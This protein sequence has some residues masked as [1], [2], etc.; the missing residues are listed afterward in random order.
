MKY[1][2]RY[3][4]I[5][6]LGLFCMSLA[7]CV[8]VTPVDMD[9]IPQ[10]E[11]FKRD[12]KKWAEEEEALRKNREDSIALVEK[13]KKLR[14]KYL[15]DLREYKKS[16]HILMFGWFAY[17]NPTSPDKTFSLDHLPDSMDFVSNWGASWNLDQVK[18]D[19]L[20]RLHE[21][22]TRM[23]IGWI[24]EN[25]GDGLRNAP[26]GG[27]SN[28]PYTAIDQYAQ[29]LCD[30]IAKYNYDGIDIDYEPQ[31]ASP[32]KPGNHC[33][34][35]T[36]PWE[37]T[38]ALISCSPN[39]N[40]EYENY[41]FRKLDELLPEEKLLNIN[42]SIGWIDPEVADVFDYFVFQSYGNSARSWK[43]TAETLMSRNPNI[44]P[45]QFIYTESFQNNPANAAAFMR[46]ADFVKNNLGGKVGGIGAFHINEDYLYGPE[47]K[48]VK[49]VISALNKPF[50]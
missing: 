19:Q 40:K 47:Y 43:Q 50:N 17:W 1:F 6:M 5:M 39:E 10:E 13:N 21:K 25:I 12:S 20:S 26:E 7:S 18:K 35:W 29:A 30:S 42:G 4:V 28:E 9:D 15:V 34:D 41:F 32:F 16:E 46:Y 45:E 23:T 37:T 36:T 38:R 8:D 11:L 22:G 49:R 31:F 24:I 3:I 33:G 2:N 14:E 48:N 27:W 44:K